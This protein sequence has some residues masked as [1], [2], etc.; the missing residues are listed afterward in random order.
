MILRALPAL[1]GANVRRLLR[2]GMVR[3]ALGFPVVLTV[4]TLLATL[5]VVAVSRG[6]PTV[7]VT[8]AVT[9]E[10]IA[11][12]EAADLV[13]VTT[14]DPEYAV[15][16]GDADAAFDGTTLFMGEGRGPIQAEGALRRA[17]NSPWWVEAEPLPSTRFTRQQG[18]IIGRLLAAIYAL[19]GVVF[20]AGMVAR[21]RDDA[22]LEVELALPV[23]RILHGLAR[24]IAGSAVL[25]LW[26][27]LGVSLAGALLGLDDT[28]TR[29]LDA[30]AGSTMAVAL[31]LAS[32]GRAGLRSGFAGSL[33]AGLAVTTGLLG[34]GYGLPVLG[35]Y[36]PLAS[37]VATGGLIPFAVSLLLGLGAV[38]IFTLR[39][40]RA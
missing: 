40:A 20:G 36:L 12:F 39:S 22:T 30:L 9:D 28:P 35:H 33:A 2:E 29:M 11:M 23:P 18:S 38:A 5:V 10:D 16:H 21:D 1:L 26:V 32:I 13:V 14:D 3:R 24:W 31:G 25:G 17:R 34:L 27:V 8:D 19:Y 15:A 37:I 4:G 6:L 7:A